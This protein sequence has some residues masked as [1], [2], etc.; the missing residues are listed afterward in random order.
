LDA[1]PLREEANMSQ[2]HITRRTAATRLSVWLGMLVIALAGCADQG[3]A[4]A[5]SEAATRVP[6][7]DSVEDVM[8]ELDGM[9]SELD[10]A[11]PEDPDVVAVCD[12]FFT[13]VVAL[14]QSGNPDAMIE[15]ADSWAASA[16]GSAIEAEAAAIADK[17][18]Q[19]ARG[20]IGPETQELTSASTEFGTQCALHG[21]VPS[22]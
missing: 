17:L 3:A 20:E 10:Q 11:L 1:C 14:A 12:E 22:Q 7:M 15:A 6:E 8:S 21:W 18:T 2:R 4:E 9:P 19:V 16:E 13:D 5:V